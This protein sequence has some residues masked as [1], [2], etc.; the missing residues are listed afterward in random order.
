MRSLKKQQ[1]VFVPSCRDRRFGLEDVVDGR[2]GQPRSSGDGGDLL[3][4]G[5]EAEDRLDLLHGDLQ[6]TPLL[7][8]APSDAAS[9]SRFLTGQARE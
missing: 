2:A 7:R 1:Q 8:P 5:L 9:P 4:L 3:A 6:P